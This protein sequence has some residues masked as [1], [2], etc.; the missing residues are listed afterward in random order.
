MEKNSVSCSRSSWRGGHGRLFCRKAII[1]G[2]TWRF[3]QPAPDWIPLFY[4][5]QG[6]NCSRRLTDSLK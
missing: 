3:S 5:N 4:D 6:V 2:I 1:V